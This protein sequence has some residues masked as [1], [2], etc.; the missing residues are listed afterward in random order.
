MCRCHF[1]T[2]K[3]KSEI[4]ITWQKEI[5]LQL[6]FGDVFQIWIDGAAEV[7][8]FNPLSLMS[9]LISI[10]PQPEDQMAERGREGGR[11]GG[12]GGGGGWGGGDAATKLLWHRKSV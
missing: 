9:R 3:D 1:I 4:V 8:K 6:L 10:N 7:G 2:G 11:E 12:G 5:R